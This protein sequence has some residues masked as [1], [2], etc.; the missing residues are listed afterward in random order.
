MST[1]R[2][3]R[4]PS[5]VEYDAFYTIYVDQVPDG[6]VVDFMSEQLD[7]A[8][9]L[10]GSVSAD[11]ANYRYAPEKWSIKELLGHI[12]DTEWIFTYRA[13]RFARGDGTALAGMDQ[14]VFVAGSNFG[15]RGL[16]SL[17][18]EFRNLRSANLILFDSFDE[19]IMVR[20]GTAADCPFTVRS[21]LFVLAGHA[22]HHL[23]VL[24]G[25]YL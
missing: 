21:M 4:R 5:S 16:R 7:E 25:H 2:D 12:L 18:D 11:K 22:Q 1:P 10:F 9:A 24:R 3:P 6:D 14:D 15:D 20:A 19:E 17:V 8:L 23:E 13:L